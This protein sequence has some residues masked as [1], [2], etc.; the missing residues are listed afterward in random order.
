MAMSLQARLLAGLAAVAI[1]LISA[2][3]IVTATTRNRLFDQVDARLTVATADRGTKFGSP[4]PDDGRDQPRPASEPPERLGDLYEGILNSDGSLV[5]FFE[6]NLPG[7]DYG[8]PNLDDVDTAALAAGSRLF[9]VP[10]TENTVRYRVATRP[11]GDGSVF[12]AA[13]PLA[14]IDDTMSRLLAVE[15]VAVGL[16]LLGLAAVAWWVIRLGIRPI[17]A[18]TKSAGEIA[19]GD[20]DVR[21]PETAPG[22]ESGALAVALNGMLGRIEAATNARAE[23]D[24]RLRRFV[25]DASHELRTPVTTIRGYSELYQAGGLHEPT[26]L[27]D[28]MR[29]TNEEAQ[30]MGRL[31]EDML[32][33]AKLDQERPLNNVPV[34]LAR[35]ATDA[36]RDARAV[37]PD[38]D[39]RLVA[40]QPTE[41]LGDVDRLRQVIANIVGNAIAHTPAETPIAIEVSRS[42]DHA[43]LAVRDWGQGM[44]AEVA[45]RVTERFYRADPSRSR[46]RGGSGLGMS[47]VDAVV[48]AHGGR[49]ELDSELGSGTTVRIL[50]PV[51]S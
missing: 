11:T 14:D 17:K 1:V 49:I 13:L 34:D 51:A 16:V 2:S 31:V 47:I 18:I 43:V 12:V 5:T 21:V 15:V 41:V 46:P 22:T 8:S 29:R 19:A 39:V 50:L 9:T 6:P 40:D 32:V 23:S 4:K 30:R 48:S 33:L 28:A 42:G 24:A 37:A 10:A 45:A 35:L 7:Q 36:A 26:E 3:A 44:S 38:R 27:A 20:L 25:A